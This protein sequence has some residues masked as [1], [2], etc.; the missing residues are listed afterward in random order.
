M[1]VSKK[2]R[3]ITITHRDLCIRAAK[4]LRSNG[5]VPFHKCAYSVCELERI[6]ECPD[7]FGW[8]SGSTQLIEAKAT[9][10]DFLSD[11]KK[12]WRKN[13][14]FGLGSYRSYICPEG[15]IEE[16]ELPRAWGLLY[17]LESGKILEIKEA[18]SQ[19][20]SHQAEVNL[21]SSILR[22]N[23]IKPQMFSY[24][25]YAKKKEEAR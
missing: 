16:S 20:C 23:E 15:L 8:S 7:A 12:Y 10:S 2:N 14:Y 4:Y 9:R 21:I 22:R 18:E 17:V 19:A 11:K 24:K 25:E 6:G 13:P 3:E 5:I 1:T